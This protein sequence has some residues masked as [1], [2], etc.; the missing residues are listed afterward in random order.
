MSFPV[1]F[2]PNAVR[3]IPSFSSPNIWTTP[4][5]TREYT[6]CSDVF[7]S[8]QRRSSSPRYAQLVSAVTILQTT[9]L[10]FADDNSG[11]QKK[12]CAS[13]IRAVST[14]LTS[15]PLQVQNCYAS[16]VGDNLVCWDTQL[17]A[18]GFYSGLV[19]NFNPFHVNSNTTD[20]STTQYLTN[21]DLQKQIGAVSD[22]TENNIYVNYGW[23]TTGAFIRNSRP[24]LEGLIN[25]G[26]LVGMW[27]GDA[28]CCDA[29]YI[30]AVISNPYLTSWLLQ[31]TGLRW[32]L[33]WN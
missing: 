26:I 14:A 3:R 25:R 12:V 11:I 10:W 19:G 20:L 33:L 30:V 15:G 13:C 31:R 1:S 18:Q 8:Y 21:P 27:S 16:T 17:A 4:S 7:F 2:T 22:Y 28:V 6:F 24:I 29:L 32:Q 23:A 9:R 5:V